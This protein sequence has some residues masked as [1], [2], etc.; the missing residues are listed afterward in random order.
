[1]HHNTQHERT[2]APAP[3][4]LRP[5]AD[6][7][8]ALLKGLNRWVLWNVGKP[9]TD[10]SGRYEK[11]PVDAATGRA[12]N[13]HDSRYWMAFEE[14]MR[15]YDSGKFAGIAIDLPND[16]E[17]ISRDA[18][19]TPLYLIGGDL[20]HCIFLG[21]D[22]KPVIAPESKEVLLRLGVPYWEKSPS[23]TGLRFF[24]LSRER[25]KNGS[26]D[27]RE[28]YSTG[29]FLTITGRGQGE[30]REASA[31]IMALHREWFPPK[32]PTTARSGN[33][34]ALL[35]PPQEPETEANI[36]RVRGALAA[37]P[38][39]CPYELWRDLVFSV[40]S[41]GWQSAEPLALDWSAKSKTFDEQAFVKLVRSFRPEGGISLGTLFFHAREAGWADPKTVSCRVSET[42]NDAANA[43]RLVAA[44]GERLR[45]VSELRCWLVWWGG[46]WRF[47]KKGQI[48]EVA[49]RSAK[50]IFTE[51]AN[52]ENPL[53]RNALS[54]WANSSLQLSRLEA[55]VRLAQSSL[56]V[57]VT[58]LDADPMLLGVKNGVIDLRT[59]H[60]RAAKPED[61]ITR[62]AGVEYDPAATCPVWDAMLDGCMGHDKSLVGLLQRASGYS[63]TGNT[64][65]QVFFFLHGP[66][67]NGKTTFVN[68]LRELLGGH[69]LQSQPETIMAHRSTNPS[70]PTPE[71]ARLAGARFVAMVETE[72]GQRLAEARI[73]QMTGG[74]AMTARVLQGAPFDFVPIFKLWLAGNHRPVIRGDDGGI[75]RRIVLIPFACIIPPEK[76][77]RN[78]P[79]KLRREYPG[80]LN[81]AITGCLLWQKQGLALPDAIAR[82]VSAYKSAMDLLAQWLDERCAVAPANSWGAR[83]AY[84][85]HTAWLK[86]G[87]HH[88]ITEV[89]FSERMI[90]RGFSKSRTKLGAFY[91]GIAPRQGVLV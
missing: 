17:P 67:A 27:G 11:I 91:S 15:A 75:W 34:S 64:D 24:V 3:K 65:E 74:D 81:W 4:V 78:L 61:L 39:D 21:A 56:A 35:A 57:S 53:D 25:L 66:G 58:E 68:V 9:K 28:L 31:E 14:V 22:N 63:L 6:K 84:Q 10:G 86:E 13:A 77:D 76:R 59:G 44:F 5:R 46:H 69:G 8:P 90:E 19:G 37:L 50:A 79:S 82:E 72:D 88:P 40:L 70:G 33:L 51:A 49:Q 18:D 45:Y 20:D 42:L 60:F 2:P 71:I 89:R 23:G 16:A 85:N 29:R 55:M 41:T 48:I 62:I 12:I 1:M 83:A 43:A 52:A 80:I 54:R 32:S 26:A 47:D 36:A 30:I 38:A 87:G 7:V 73:K